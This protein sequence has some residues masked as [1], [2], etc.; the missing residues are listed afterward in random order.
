MLA[1]RR[2]RCLLKSPALLFLAAWFL[3]SSFLSLPLWAQV[4]GM[5]SMQIQGVPASGIGGTVAGFS[6]ARPNASAGSASYFGCCASFFFPSSFSPMVPYSSPA[7]GHR[8][9]RRHHRRNDQ[10]VGVVEPAYIPAAVPAGDS[11]GVADGSSSDE[12]DAS[13]VDDGSTGPSASSARAGR[14]QVA[15]GVPDQQPGDEAGSG[16]G[17]DAEG[18]SGSDAAADPA[19]DAPPPEPP[20]PVVAQPTTVLVFKDGHRSEVVNYAIVGDTL[21]DFSGD[22]THKIPIADLDLAATQRANDASGVEFKLPPAGDGVPVVKS[23][24]N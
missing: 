6:G 18:D 20:E 12:G 23:G 8:S 11:D 16:S 17:S 21:F 19:A 1:A 4:Q 22:R 9:G 24:A 15:Q 3:P 10:L 2:F 13:M 7:T 14:R 5:P